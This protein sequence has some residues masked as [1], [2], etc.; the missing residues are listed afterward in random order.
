MSTSRDLLSVSASFPCSAANSP[1]ASDFA[2]TAWSW[3]L[4]QAGL[5]AVDQMLEGLCR[6]FDWRGPY[7]QGEE[8]CRE[9]LTEL[10]P[11]LGTRRTRLHVQLLAWQ[12]H[13]YRVVGDFAAAGAALQG[14][15]GVVFWSVAGIAATALL[16]ATRFPRVAVEPAPATARA[17]ERT[18]G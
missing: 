9:A 8:L 16:V 2:R 4:R 5:A 7:Q 14:A 3:A 1:K 6:F 12:G 10:R 18:E 11:L 13:F 15:M 17:A